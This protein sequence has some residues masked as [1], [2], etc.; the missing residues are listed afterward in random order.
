MCGEICELDSD[1]SDAAIAYCT[2]P[3]LISEFSISKYELA[4][5]EELNIKWMDEDETIVTLLND[6]D[7][8]YDYE[9]GTDIDSCSIYGELAGANH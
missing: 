3:P 6:G 8:T 1:E 9:S 2:L 7:L 5:L 4:K